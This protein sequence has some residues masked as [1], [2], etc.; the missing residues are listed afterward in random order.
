MAVLVVAV[1]LTIRL[2]ELELLI[3]V[4]LVEVQVM[5]LRLIVAAV[6]VVLAQQVQA[7]FLPLLMVVM[8]LAYLNWQALHKQVFLMSMQAEVEVAHIT[9]LQVMEAL[10]AEELEANQVTEALLFQIQA[11][12]AVA[13]DTMDMLLVVMVVQA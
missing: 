10:V 3:K 11:A 7:A 12:V 4:L 5:V 6:A 1:V 9:A 8:E 2:V 13:Q